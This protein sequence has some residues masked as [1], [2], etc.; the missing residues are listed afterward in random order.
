MAMA[1]AQKGKWK[2][3]KESSRQG[4]NWNWHTVTFAYSLLAKAS[5]VIVYTFHFKWEDL[6]SYKK[7]SVDTGESKEMGPLS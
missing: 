7:K 4:L 1:E 6:L 3:G 2:F 5:Q